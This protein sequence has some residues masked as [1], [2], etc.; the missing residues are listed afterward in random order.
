MPI[1]SLLSTLDGSP[2][3]Y[4]SIARDIEAIQQT[5]AL[6]PLSVGIVSTFTLDHVKPYIVVESARRGFLASTYFAPFNQLEQE[7]LDPACGLYRF[8]PDII[9]I[10]ARL[11][12]LAPDL[13][14][15]FL[16][17]SHESTQTEMTAL[18]GRF[19]N[20]IKAARAHSSGSILVFNQAEPAQ[21]AAGIAD[22]QL[23]LS[24]RSVIHQLN[25]K[26]GEICKKCADTFIFDH[27][28]FMSECGLHMQD[29]RLWY[30]ARIPFSAATLIKM[31]RRLAR[32]FRAMRRP[33]AKCLVLARDG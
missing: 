24:Q 12:E 9:V 11:E 32:F 7:L 33:S 28:R 3:S 29:T 26:L 21:L 15:R 19:E 16:T 2:V 6:E 23:V 5:P 10:A 14:N 27:A 18:A 31:G 20:L 30:M 1:N 8:N 4:L 25:I 22:A 13:T 17:F